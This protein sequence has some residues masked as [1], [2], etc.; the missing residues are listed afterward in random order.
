LSN[1]SIDVNEISTRYAKALTLVSGNDG[2]TLEIRKNFAE[3][4]SLL[5]KT[6]KLQ[7]LIANPLIKI[8]K[9]SLILEKISV[10]LK[11]SKKFR[12]FL[13]IMTKHG[14][15]PYVEKIY[16]QFLAILNSREGVTDV[17]ITTSVPIESQ[18]ENSLKKKLSEKL[19]LKVNLNK[20]IN[21]EIIGGIIIQIRS[22]MIDHSVK[23]K[24]LDYKLDER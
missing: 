6:D 1:K 14:K 13:L 19:K 15:L 4:I 22:I 16:N 11:F 3:F 9:K 23:S 21:P 24:L 10:K 5:K 2:E 17:I 18:L 8:K 7:N 12:G 20:I